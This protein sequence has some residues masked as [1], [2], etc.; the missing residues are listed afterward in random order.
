MNYSNSPAVFNF[1]ATEVRTIADPE[2]GIMFCAKDVCE[3][4]GIKW[5]GAKS[6]LGNIPEHWKGY[7]KLH[8]PR[9]EQEGVFITEPAMY[10]LIFRSNKPSAI[11]FTN[12]VCEEVL[13]TIH[14]QGFYGRISVS[15]Q[16]RLTS[17]KIKLLTMLQKEKS[18]F[19][20]DALRRSLTNT[21]NLLGEPMPNIE[22]LNQPVEQQSLI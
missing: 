21:C 13:P 7:G 4:V 15:E 6:T 17:Q 10:R 1:E 9:G 8:T 2:F 12:W 18:R 19:G 3:A 22:T 5:I 11:A 16:I 14:K 20:F